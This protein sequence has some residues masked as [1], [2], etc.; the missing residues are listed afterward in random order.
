MPLYLWSLALRG[1]NK[2]GPGHVVPGELLPVA[3]GL[4]SRGLVEVVEQLELISVGCRQ[5][6]LLNA[7]LSFTVVK[8][9]L[10]CKVFG[11][12]LSG[13]GLHPVSSLSTAVTTSDAS[14]VVR[15]WHLRAGGCICQIAKCVCWFLRRAGRLADN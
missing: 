10:A 6:P 14:D 12:R 15:H 7:L 3:R 9:P 4:L 1:L 8:R 11:G 13:L 2:A 5:L